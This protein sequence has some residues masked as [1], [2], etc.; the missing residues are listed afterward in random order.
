[1]ETV[2]KE[3]PHVHGGSRGPVCP[4]WTWR[5]RLGVRKIEFRMSTWFRVNMIV[6]VGQ[7]QGRFQ[8][9]KIIGFG[10]NDDEKQEVKVRVE[11]DIRRRW[12]SREA[13]SFW[14]RRCN[15]FVSRAE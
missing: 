13:T 2:T 10:R 5:H 6:L 15:W 8:Q 7:K 11:V 4:K 9:A 3:K 1:M 14:R 12:P